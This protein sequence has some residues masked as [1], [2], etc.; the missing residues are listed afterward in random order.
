MSY[1]DV[2][3]SIHLCLYAHVSMCMSLCLCAQVFV[4]TRLCLCGHCKT[5]AAVISQ[6]LPFDAFYSEGLETN[7]FAKSL[8]QC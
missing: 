7:K 2:F 8:N 6:L 1:A 5:P 4:C 3:E